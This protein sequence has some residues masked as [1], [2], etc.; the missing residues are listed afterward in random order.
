MAKTRRDPARCRSHDLRR[1]AYDVGLQLVDVQSGDVVAEVAEV[2]NV[3]GVQEVREVV[4]DQAAALRKKL[5]DLVTGPPVVT[6]DTAPAGAIVTIDG[7]P[8]GDRELMEAFDEI[9][10]GRGET[11]V[12]YFEFGTLAAVRTFARRRVALAILE[13]GIGG[14]LDD[15][16]AGAAGADAAI[17]IEAAARARRIARLHQLTRIRL[18]I[19]MMT[20]RT[21]I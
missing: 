9:D 15:D 7:E 4:A 11:T 14:R 20:Q 5:D 2:C 12:T 21:I 6:I 1:Q 19:K 18:I 17:R 3:C 8:A 16:G 10:A 13:V